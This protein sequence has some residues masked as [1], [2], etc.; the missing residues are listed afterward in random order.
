MLSG[1]ANAAAKVMLSCKTFHR[2]LAAF[3]KYFM[4]AQLKRQN[5]KVKTKNPFVYEND[6]FEQVKKIYFYSKGKLSLATK[7]S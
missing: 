7:R 3:L 1:L 2:N 4:L 6:C 5:R